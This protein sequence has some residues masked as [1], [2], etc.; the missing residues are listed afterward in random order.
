MQDDTTHTCLDDD[1]VDASII[2]LL[3]ESPVAG[4]WSVDELARELQDSLAV[5]D[6]LT[7][8]RAMALIHRMGDLVF[9]TRVAVR[10][11]ELVR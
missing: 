4:P 10:A 9:P 11:Y 5:T 3:I 6:A 2:R 7:R 8:L 1:D